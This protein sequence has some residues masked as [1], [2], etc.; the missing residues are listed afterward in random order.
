MQEAVA[1]LRK[2]KANYVQR[3][4]DWERAKVD[5][6]VFSFCFFFVFSSSAA[7]LLRFALHHRPP[8]LPPQIRARNPSKTKPSV[9]EWISIQPIR[10]VP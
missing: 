10:P 8:P 9:A 6:L 7:S 4:Q 1:N 5:S 3:Q 2:A